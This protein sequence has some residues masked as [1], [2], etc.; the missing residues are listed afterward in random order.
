MI[1]SRTKSPRVRFRCSECG[2]TRERHH[3]ARKCHCGGMLV[4]VVANPDCCPTCGK[5]FKTESP[6]RFCRLCKKPILKGHKFRWVNLDG[7][8]TTI[9]HRNCDE[10]NSYKPS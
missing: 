9:E 1:I 10:P 2:T 4:R 3:N 7:N 5:P 8:V 6:V